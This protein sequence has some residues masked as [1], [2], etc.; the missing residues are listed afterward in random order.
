VVNYAQNHQNIELLRQSKE[1]MAR[2]RYQAA[3]GKKGE[4][5]T[6]LKGNASGYLR[7]E[8][9]KRK[10]T[11]YIDNNRYIDLRL[12]KVE[13]T[14]DALM[15]LT[16]KFQEF[17]VSCRGTMIPPAGQFMASSFLSQVVDQLNAQDLDKRYI[18]AG[19]RTN[20]APINLELMTTSANSNIVDTSYYTGDNTILQTALDDSMKINYG[21][22]ASHPAFES[23]IRSMRMAGTLNYSLSM[24]SAAYEAVLTAAQSSM[25]GLTSLFVQLGENRRLITQANQFHQDN[26]QAVEASIGKKIEVDPAEA[27]DQIAQLTRQINSAYYGMNQLNNLSLL[28][29]LK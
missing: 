25:S 22:L 10:I 8:D 23:L 4:A 11:T 21:V 7:E 27:I 28:N 18:F 6:D 9:I 24:D 15:N 5:Y 16:R 17:L 13:L 14:L 3:T 1:E 20:M 12:E 2:R 26:L 19:A 29:F